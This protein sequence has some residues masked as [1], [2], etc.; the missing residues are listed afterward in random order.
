LA[1]KKL[2]DEVAAKNAKRRKKEE[3]YATEAH[4]PSTMNSGAENYEKSHL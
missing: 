3:E 1:E 4:S 2:K